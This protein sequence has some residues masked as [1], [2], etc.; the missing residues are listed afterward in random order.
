M[1]NDAVN[2]R[3]VINPE[4]YQQHIQLAKD[5]AVFLRRNIVQG[6]RVAEGNQEN[7]E[8]WRTCFLE[9]VANEY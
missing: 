9:L 4:E 6:M 3:S 2:A 1:R 5:V 8:T 7:D